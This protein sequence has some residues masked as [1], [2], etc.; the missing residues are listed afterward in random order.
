MLRRV[1][2]KRGP[3]RAASVD[4]Y[5]AVVPR[6]A[7]A[8]LE[9]LRQTIRTAAPEATEVISYQIPTYKHH[10]PLVAFAAFPQHC[11]FYVMSKA[12]MDAHRAELGSYDTAKATIRFQASKPLPAALV[13]K[14]V[15]ARIAENEKARRSREAGSLP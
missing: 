3:A 4:D 10:G 11:G 15:K 9:K 13:R 6:E 2:G 1:A 7:R 8:A 14:L 5:L 12:V